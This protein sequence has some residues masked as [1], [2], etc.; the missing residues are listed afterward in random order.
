MDIRSVLRNGLIKNRGVLP[1]S[2][3]ET[4]EKGSKTFEN[5]SSNSIAISIGYKSEGE[6]R[7]GE[8]KKKRPEIDDCEEN[9]GE[10]E[11]KLRGER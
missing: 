8:T 11:K 3:N 5:E 1:S 9:G 6:R 10:M 4:R 7:R 2:V